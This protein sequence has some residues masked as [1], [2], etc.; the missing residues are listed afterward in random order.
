MALA[1]A[2]TIFPGLAKA[3]LFPISTAKS[4]LKGQF[5]SIKE[6]AA[7]VTRPLTKV[8]RNGFQECLQ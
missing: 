5:T 4:L 3:Q 1:E 7:K 6:V 2:F 8:S